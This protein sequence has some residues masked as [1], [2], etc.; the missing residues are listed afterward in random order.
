[1]PAHHG[2][3]SVCFLFIAACFAAAGA[4]DAQTLPQEYGNLIR[5]GSNV[6]A[7]DAGLL[8]E[9]IDYYTGHVDFVATDVSLPGNNAL[10]VAIGRRYAVD[11]NPSGVVP[12]RRLRVPQ[13]DACKHMHIGTLQRARSSN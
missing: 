9:R 11:A 3:R 8:G 13:R 5:A 12:G 1:M 4:L 10:P 6:G 7:L 2:S